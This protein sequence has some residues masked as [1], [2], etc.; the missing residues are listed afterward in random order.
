[1]DIDIDDMEALALADVFLPETGMEF[2]ENQSLEA[3]GFI[4]AKVRGRRRDF[5]AAMGS[6]SNSEA[7]VAKRCFRHQF[8]PP[9]STSSSPRPINRQRQIGMISKPTS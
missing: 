6:S 7:T 8:I 4:A 5:R 2:G 3:I 9:V 1:M